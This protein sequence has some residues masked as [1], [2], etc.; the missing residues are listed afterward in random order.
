MHWDSITFDGVLVYRK[1]QWGPPV[2]SGAVDVGVLVDEELRERGGIRVDREVQRV[3]AALLRLV[4]E[5]VLA[6]HPLLVALG[7]HVLAVLQ[8][9]HQLLK[10]AALRGG[11]EILG[12]PVGEH[13]EALLEV[14]HLDLAGAPIVLLAARALGA[15][16][17]VV[18]V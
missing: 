15:I 17:G 5:A 4:Q 10:G 18:A 9:R 1:L 2:R 12:E 13:I 3:P 16:E 11:E 7:R 6:L 8:Q 14:V